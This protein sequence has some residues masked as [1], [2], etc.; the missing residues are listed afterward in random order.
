[1][2]FAL[3]ARKQNTRGQFTNPEVPFDLVRSAS[4]RQG[5]HDTAFN[6]VSEWTESI[7]YNEGATLSQ[8]QANER[9]SLP[10]LEFN[11]PVREGYAKLLYQRKQQEIS[12][13]KAMQLGVDG[14]FSA[15]GLSSLA[16]SIVGNNMSPTDF[17]FNFF[18]ATAATKYGRAL[19]RIGRSGGAGRVLGGLGRPVVREGIKRIPLYRAMAASVDAAVGNA[20]L[21]V[22]LYFGDQRD[23]TVHTIGMSLINV[24]AGATFGASLSGV[25]SA[26]RAAGRKWFSTSKT[27]RMEAVRAASDDMINGRQTGSVDRIVDADTNVIRGRVESGARETLAVAIREAEAKTPSITRDVSKRIATE[28]AALIQRTRQDLIDLSEAIIPVMRERGSKRDAGEIAE[29]LKR[30]KSDPGHSLDLLSLAAFSELSD[31]S[32]GVS[33]LVKGDKTGK[34]SE[35]V[36]RIKGEGRPIPLLGEL[37][38][39]IGER[40]VAIT[41]R[42]KDRV[43]RE[44]RAERIRLVR[45]SYREAL[46]QEQAQNPQVQA[47]ETAKA[48][49]S[50]EPPP[51]P[52]R[53]SEGPKA[54][55]RDTSD[56]DAEIQDLTSQ[57]G[58]DAPASLRKP[59]EPVDAEAIKAG[60]SCLMGGV[61]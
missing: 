58:D 60:T 38:V 16:V 21:E 36:S 19:G 41:P 37:P 12:R 3:P 14:F 43:A 15:R 54:V 7:I 32:G 46:R 2:P 50:A 25:G 1:M 30:V 56:F 6:Q 48:I 28:Q 8:E 20:I 31:I 35:V 17:A 5:F 40:L 11:E 53:Q 51:R 39:S 61:L 10:G 26:L 47:A 13:H 42:F 29:A 18:P 49:Q 59:V 23:H 57:L 45:E 52:L 44:V 27:T 4:F 24:A 33:L 55:Q 22:P 34:I 9:F